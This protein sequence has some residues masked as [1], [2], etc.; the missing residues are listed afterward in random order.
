MTLGEEH[1]CFN[2]TYTRKWF[3]IIAKISLN[4]VQ[5]LDQ[6]LEGVDSVTFSFLITAV[7]SQQGQIS[8]L[9][10]TARVVN[11]T[12]KTNKHTLFSAE[13][14]KDIS[15]RF[16]NTKSFELFTTDVCFVIFICNHK[17]TYILGLL[18]CPNY[19]FKANTGFVKK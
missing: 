15:S 9:I 14:P 11:N 16:K 3:H 1:F 4:V 8:L 5:I 17:L 6:Y 10:T 18:S 13:F 2:W 12:R 19:F 7:N